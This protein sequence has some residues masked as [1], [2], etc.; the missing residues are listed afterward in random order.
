[1]NK[2]IM[3][4]P[5]AILT[6]CNSEGA[7]QDSTSTD[8]G[9]SVSPGTGGNDSNDT[10]SVGGE[11]KLFNVAFDAPK[12]LLW[13]I[14][15][16]LKA[17]GSYD[18]DTQKDISKEAEWQISNHDAGDYRIHQNVIKAEIKDGFDISASFDGVESKTVSVP[19]YDLSGEYIDVYQAKSGKYYTSPPSV[20]FIKTLMKSDLSEYVHTQ[21]LIR[22]DVEGDY[23]AFV[24][25]KFDDVCK[26]FRDKKLNG[27][28][29]WRLPTFDE[30]KF[31]AYG[32]QVEEQAISQTKLCRSTEAGRQI[33]NMSH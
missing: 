27:F 25:D 22:D 16:P 19:V 28:S 24:Q 14:K 23:Y 13:R 1:M 7:F 32:T 10:G 2:L 12:Y 20:A 11:G 15:T 5:L 18:D 31:D 6:G 29:D 33:F 30:L 26:L 21:E 9:S 17:M 3:L 4:L 8:T